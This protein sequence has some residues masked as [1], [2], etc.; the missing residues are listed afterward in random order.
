[1]VRAGSNPAEHQKKKNPQKEGIECLPFSECDVTNAHYFHHV[2]H[3]TIESVHTRS[4]QQPCANLVK[5]EKSKTEI[6]FGEVEHGE[7]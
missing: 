1:M 6:A 5:F 3:R 4:N 2:R 7:N